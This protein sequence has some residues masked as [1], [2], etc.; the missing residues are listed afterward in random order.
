MRVAHTSNPVGAWLILNVDLAIDRFRRAGTSVDIG[1]RIDRIMQHTQHVVV[2]NLSPGNLSL[3][4][5][6]PDPP[7]KEEVLRIESG[8]RS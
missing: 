6:A 1:A 3:M 8:G 4:G 7:W 2:L 5:P